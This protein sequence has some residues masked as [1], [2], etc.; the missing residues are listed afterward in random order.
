MVV[1]PEMLAAEMDE[2]MLAVFIEYLSIGCGRSQ[3]KLESY[4]WN[5]I[6]D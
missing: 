6:L 1:A 2:S 3:L 4:I 5:T